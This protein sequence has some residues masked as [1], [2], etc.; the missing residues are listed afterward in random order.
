M[1][2]TKIKPSPNIK[3]MVFGLWFW[4]NTSKIRL[5]N[6][7]FYHCLEQIFQL[8]YCIFFCSLNLQWTFLKI[9]SKSKFNCIWILLN[10]LADMKVR[11]WILFGC[12]GDSLLCLLAL[13]LFFFSGIVLSFQLFHVSFMN[14]NLSFFFIF[15]SF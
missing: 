13:I 3:H 6:S 1:S 8:F 10:V 14:L 2:P 15:L 5:V 4:L 11:Y 9:L 7:L 12:E